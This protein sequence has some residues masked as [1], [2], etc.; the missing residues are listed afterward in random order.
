M[1]AVTLAEAAEPSLGRRLGHTE[2][3]EMTQERVDAFADV[4]EDH[5]YIHVDVER[6]K[7]VAVRRHDRARVSDRVA[8]GADLPAAA[9]RSPTRP[10]STT[11]WTG[12]ASRRRCPSARSSA[13]RRRSPRSSEIKGGV[14][15][16]V[17]W[18]GRGQG[19]P[20]GRRSSPTACSGTTHERARAGRQGRR[21]H[22]E[23]ARPRPRLR[24][25]AGAR[26]RRRGGQRPRRRRGAGDRGADRRR[27]RP[28][29]RRGARGRRHRRGRRAG[30]P[31]GGRVRPPRRHGHQ[32]RRAARPGAVEDDR[33]GLRRGRADA[34]ARDVHVRARG[35]VQMRAQEDGRPD[36]RGRLAGRPARQLRADE[37]RR[38]EGRHR[39]VR[40]HVGDG[41]RA[42][43]D[44]GQRD[45][46]DGVDADDGE[47]PDL[48]AARRAGRGRRAAA[49]RGPPG[50]RDR[51]ARGQ[52]R[53]RRLPRLRRGRRRSPARRSA[54]AAT[55]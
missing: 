48:R 20:S 10:A 26:R 39:R 51:H 3:R 24:G 38:G 36:H 18:H 2:W 55:G 22:R 23:R 28:R 35:G 17:R 15:V 1:T 42:Q 45:R 25:R 53:A 14:Q 31:R 7:D 30:R 41:A 49:A 32:R 43:R 9:A 6:A 27:R 54:S 46:A 34:P 40:A 33:R 47:H 29:G 12:C 19:L 13:A 11:A 44:H 37:L 16:K 50:A 5:N 52:R 4:T 21:R 8:A